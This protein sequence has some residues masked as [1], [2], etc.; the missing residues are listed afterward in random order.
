MKPAS[1]IISILNW[2]I[3]TPNE[4]TD[5]SE[6]EDYFGHYGRQ[7]NFVNSDKQL[8]LELENELLMFPNC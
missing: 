1:L 7:Y 5:Q 8:L 2:S 3:T 4:G 6:K